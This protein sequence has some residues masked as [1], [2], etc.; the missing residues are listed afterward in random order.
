MNAR[1]VTLDGSQEAVDAYFADRGWSDGLPIVP[2]TPERVL[3]FLSVADE[4]PER[5]LGAIPP[6]N[7]VATLEKL[8]INAVM[9]G[10]LPEYFPVVTTAIAAML[11]EPFNLLGVQSTTHP[12]APLVIVN[13]PKVAV[14][15]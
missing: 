12:C 2:P 9:A 8:A 6:R 10:C 4:P 1:R 5:E 3:R 11:E 13:G 7:G 15:R 14:P